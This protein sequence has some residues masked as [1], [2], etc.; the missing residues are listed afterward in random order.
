MAPAQ[1]KR[2]ILPKG[3]RYDVHAAAQHTQVICQR[4]AQHDVG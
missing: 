1:K 4:R 2:V 3:V